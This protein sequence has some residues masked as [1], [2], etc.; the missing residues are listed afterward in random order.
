MSKCKI[1]GAAHWQDNLVSC[2]L[3]HNYY[4]HSLFSKFFL[5][6]IAKTKFGCKANVAET[7]YSFVNSI[8]LNNVVIVVELKEVRR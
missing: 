3:L 5:S 1:L 6:L 8:L 7:V 4:I 2:F